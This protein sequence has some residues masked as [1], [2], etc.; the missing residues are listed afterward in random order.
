MCQ[1]VRTH[2]LLHSHDGL[3]KLC[4][5]NSEEYLALE[6][7]SSEGSARS[8]PNEDCS[9]RPAADNRVGPPFTTSSPSR[10]AR[11]AM[12]SSSVPVGEPLTVFHSKTLP[13]LSLFELGCAINWR[14]KCGEECQLIALVL[15][16]RYCD[17]AKVQPTAHMM[18][19]LYITCLHVGMKAHSDELFTNTA[20]A[21][22]VGIKPR[23]LNLLEWEL[24]RALEWDLQ[25][26]QS[27]LAAIAGC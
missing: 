1:I 13:A 22:I 3:Q 8:T 6:S 24:V 4:Q 21:H 14:T 17:K 9:N 19:R 26:D 18:H 20:F 7:T 11:L 16:R 12:A 15:M 25:V 10:L 2:V 27:Q 5:Q 23:E